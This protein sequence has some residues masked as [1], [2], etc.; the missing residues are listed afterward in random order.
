MSI[1]VVSVKISLRLRRWL[2]ARFAAL[3]SPY[4]RNTLISSSKA[5]GLN[6]LIVTK[7]QKPFT[8]WS[9][10]HNLHK[11][12]FIPLPLQALIQ[13]F[14][15]GVDVILNFIY[16]SMVVTDLSCFQKVCNST[17]I[18]LSSQCFIIDILIFLVYSDILYSLKAHYSIDSN[19]QN[20][21]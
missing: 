5:R 6:K 21:I 20:P 12:I 4:N 17:N 11:L 1:I 10:Y 13:L 3:V 15:N 9:T 8:S 2:D 19:L 16:Q 7:S 14:E 18:F